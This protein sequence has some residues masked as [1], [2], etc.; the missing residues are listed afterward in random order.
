MRTRTVEITVGAFM[1]AGILSL[2]FLAFAV[3][4]YVVDDTAKLYT[5]HARFNDVSGLTTRARVTVAGVNVGR[6]SAIRVDTQRAQAIVDL[7]LNA[8]AGALSADTGAKIVTEGVLGGKYI[9]LVPGAEDE[10]LK[11]GSEIEDTQ[12]AL[13]LEDLVGQ[14]VK[15]LGE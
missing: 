8:N 15:K 5:V 7:Q 10:V 2:V 9:A 11:D 14:F 13:I 3:S 1:L 6:V 4:G 12:G